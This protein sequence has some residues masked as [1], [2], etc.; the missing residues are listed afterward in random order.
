MFKHGT[1]NPARI[2]YQNDL[3]VPRHDKRNCCLELALKNELSFMFVARTPLMH[4][5]G[6]IQ[7]IGDDQFLWFV[8]VFDVY[9]FV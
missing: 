1:N 3:T 4:G 5:Q 2:S 6:T 8:Y 9:L 7:T